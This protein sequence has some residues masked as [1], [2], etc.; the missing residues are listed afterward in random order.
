MPSRRILALVLVLLA[1][2]LAADTIRLVNGKDVNGKITDETFAQIEY[3]RAGVSSK[4]TINSSDVVS[5]LYSSTT[6]EWREAMTL[7]NDGEMAKAALSFLK[8][9]DDEDAPGFMRAA[10]LAMAGEA[11]VTDGSYD[12]ALEVFDELLQKYPKS[13]HLARALMGKGECL[14]YA[15]RLPEA[16]QVL[17]QLKADV[18]S[19]SLGE[20]WALEAE[21]LLLWSAEAQGK[22]GVVEGY[23][24][25]RN[26][27]RAAYPGIANKA[28][29]RMGRVQL[30]KN[31]V[32]EA[33]ALFDEI[34]ASRMETDPAIVAGAYNGLGRC[35]FGRAQVLLGSGRPA[36]A[37]LQF[38]D[39]LLDFLR[40]H[41]SYP[42][43]RREQA[44]A[45]Y[46]AGQAFLNV[47]AL[48]P[49]ATD[50]D[51]R[52][53]VLLKRCRDLYAGSDWAKLAASQ[54]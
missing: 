5:V 10:A 3:R 49:A 28:A 14:F 45:L 23:Q 40:V 15:R 19:K 42:G 18:V 22:A 29:L 4:Q 24:A 2:S 50:A 11:G 7:L 43:V 35:A 8:V 13:R 41:V 53:Q 26:Q 54:R 33:E 30:D 31:N 47:G 16:D 39:S 17:N 36:D 20:R 52:G 32:R 1:P 38:Q 46:F 21:F 44:E 48:D 25:L 27:A 37:L 12:A 6:A 51:Q 9:A 34:V